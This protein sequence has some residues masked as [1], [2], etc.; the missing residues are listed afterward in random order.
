MSRA[1]VFFFARHGETEW[2]A[3]GRWQGQ[4]DI[5]LNDTGRV[6]ARTLGV[7]LRGEGIVA[8]GASDLSRARETAELASEELGIALEFTDPAFRERAYG[9]FEGLT[10]EE[11]I[12]RHPDEWSRFA[13]SPAAALPGVELLAVVAG[14]MLLGLR[15][16]AERPEHARAPVLI[17]SHGRAIRALV[18]LVTGADVPPIANGGVYR[19]VVGE[20][21]DPVEAALLGG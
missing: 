17:V 14:R 16:A 5:P 3:A 9:I 10:R 18:T 4:T 1:R 11:C 13:G 8:A 12:A 21:G 7:R 2:N 15:R 6:Q 20:N 19:V